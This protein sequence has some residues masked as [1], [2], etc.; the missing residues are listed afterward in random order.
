MGEVAIFDR[1]GMPASAE[2]T[3]DMLLYLVSY[4]RP[5][6]RA[7]LADKPLPPYTMPAVF[8]RHLL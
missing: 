4:E 8:L 5:A 6:G 2:I 1:Y 3:E 7:P